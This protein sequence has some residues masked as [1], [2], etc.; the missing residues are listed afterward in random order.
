MNEQSN[1]PS[2]LESFKVNTRFKLA[3]LWTSVMFCYLYG[4][5]FS[6]FVPGRVM[7]LNEGNSGTGTTTPVMLLCYALMMSIPAIMVFLSLV[8]KPT[9]SKWLNIVFG[10]VFTVIMAL[11]L[12]STS[13][14][15]ML[16]YSYLAVVE[17]MLTISI[18]WNAIKWLRTNANIY[19]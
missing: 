17:I 7:K 2:V 12:F 19:P 13:G 8:L 15:F 10:I 6:L 16:F 1:H 5:F 14:K 18:V 4:D 3:A 11:I 9:L